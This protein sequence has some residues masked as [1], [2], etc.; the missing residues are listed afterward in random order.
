[1]G[2][3]SKGQEEGGELAVHAVWRT[4]SAQ[5]AVGSRSG[6]PFSLRLKVLSPFP[7]KLTTMTLILF[8]LGTKKETDSSLS[9]HRL[10]CRIGGQCWKEPP[11]HSLLLTRIQ[12]IQD[13]AEG[14]A[15]GTRLWAPFLFTVLD[16]SGEFCLGL[17][18][19]LGCGSGGFG[20]L[21]IFPEG[22]P[23]QRPLLTNLSPFF[24]ANDGCPKEWLSGR[25]MVLGDDI[26]FI[27]IEFCSLPLLPL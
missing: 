16:F 5:A 27:N 20:G 15:E 18:L 10:S 22:P 2:D 19:T 13:C 25:I 26:R 14:V 7:R 1:M 3:L 23:P 12:D 4:D 9:R 24:A 21:F 6:V 8:V 11:A 17:T